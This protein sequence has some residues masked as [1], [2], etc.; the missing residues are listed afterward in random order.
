MSRTMTYLYHDLSIIS[1]G[2]ILLINQVVTRSIPGTAVRIFSSE[3][4]SV[5]FKNGMLMH[6]VLMSCAVFGGGPVH[7]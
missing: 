2:I 3:N 6:F 7:C 5:A 4:Y 1:S